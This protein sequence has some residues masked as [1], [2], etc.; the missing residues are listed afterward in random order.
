L[1]SVED[2]AKAT[3]AARAAGAAVATAGGG[4]VRRFAVFSEGLVATDAVA[5]GGELIGEVLA[6]LFGGPKAFLEIG[7]FVGAEGGGA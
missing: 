7:A 5:G 1:K 2:V 3:G 4:W 6:A